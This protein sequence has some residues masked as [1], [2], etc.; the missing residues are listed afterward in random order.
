MGQSLR[1]IIHILNAKSIE[2][3]AKIHLP[4]PKEMDE[5]TALLF[6]EINEARVSL[7]KSNSEIRGEVEIT[8]PSGKRIILGAIDKNS[9]IFIN[10]LRF[11][12]FT[13]LAAIIAYE[14]DF[15]RSFWIPLSCVAVMS[16]ATV[17]ATFHRAIQ[18]SVGT[19]FG[20]IIASLI[21]AFHPTG[22][23]IVLLIFLLTLITELFIVKNYSLAALFFTPNSL[24]MAEVVSVDHYPFSYFATARVVDVLIGVLIGLIGVWFVGRK[25]ASSSLPHLI[26]KTIRSQAQVFYAL[27]SN[28]NYSKSN[29][30]NKMKTNISNLK[31]IYDTATGEIPKNKKALEYYWPIIYTIQELGFLL[32]K[33][34]RLIKRP[35]LEDET[36]AK[37]LLIFESLANAT[38]HKSVVAMK[39]V[40]EVAGFERIKDTINRL[41]KIVLLRMSQ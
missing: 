30:F 2:D 20:I 31:T 28:E 12:A 32:D 16:G 25:S 21:L 1:A 24:I 11:G 7:L 35:V 17:V 10:S 15:A 23:T 6:M 22:Y 19:I 27:F 38:D 29:E 9:I 4:H 8:V 13:F 37:Y 41:Q 39:K 33:S 26:S 14:F 5:K 40:P 34:V 18:R 36:L 3:E